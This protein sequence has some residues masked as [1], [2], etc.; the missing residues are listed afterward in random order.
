M[1]AAGVSS[2]VMRGALSSDVAS[3]ALSSFIP[4]S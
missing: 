4:F 2:R 1:A 3:F